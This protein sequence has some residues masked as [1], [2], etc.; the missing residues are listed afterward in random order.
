MEAFIHQCGYA[1]CI[2]S[3]FPECGPVC[4]MAFEGFVEPAHDIVVERAEGGIVHPLGKVFLFLET[5]DILVVETHG[6]AHPRLQGGIGEC[7]PAQ[8]LQMLRGLGHR[9]HLRQG[10]A[11]NGKRDGTALHRQA[12]MVLELLDIAALLSGAQAVAPAVGQQPHPAGPADTAVKMIGRDRVLKLVGGQAEAPAE[13]VR[14][15]RGRRIPGRESALVHREDYQVL[16]IQGPDLQRSHD[17]QTVQRLSAEG[18][19]HRG[20]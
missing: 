11:G 1:F 9:S 12:V 2:R 19:R 7:H 3:H 5:Q 20:L 18:N 15:H 10:I 13:V 6:T 17:L 8:S 14:Y 4:G 16:E